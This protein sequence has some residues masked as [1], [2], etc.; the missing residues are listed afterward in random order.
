V[1]HVVVVVTHHVVMAVHVHVMMHHVAVHVHLMMQHV[2]VHVHHM[3]HVMMVMHRHV[4]GRSRDRREGEDHAGDGRGGKSL[5][6][7]GLH[8][9]WTT[10]DFSPHRSALVDAAT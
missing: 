1:H 7:D 2:V 8:F 10:G 5:D 3:H 9:L 6:Q 4:G